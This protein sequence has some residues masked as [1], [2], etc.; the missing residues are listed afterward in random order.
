MVYSAG[1]KENKKAVERLEYLRGE[2]RA[3][4][5]SYGEL[6]ELESFIPFISPDDL[7]LLEAAGVPENGTKTERAGRCDCTPTL[8]NGEAIHD[9]TC[10]KFDG[11]PMHQTKAERAE[12]NFKPGDLLTIHA[13]TSKQGKGLSYPAQFVIV[14][15]EGCA[16][17]WDIYDAINTDGREVSFYGFSVTERTRARL[18]KNRA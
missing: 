12:A 15:D 17:G 2:L 6:V 13:H 7:E 1:M 5:I 16:G 3:E 14:Q 4:R 18:A 10:G 9:L 8:V 11:V